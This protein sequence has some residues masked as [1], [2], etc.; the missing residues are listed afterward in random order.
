MQY[1]QIHRQVGGYTEWHKNETDV[2]RAPTV[3]SDDLSSNLDMITY[4][5][6]ALRQV[7]LTRPSVSLPVKCT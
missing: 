3:E 5:L 6:C 1:T 4:E 2:V 7:D